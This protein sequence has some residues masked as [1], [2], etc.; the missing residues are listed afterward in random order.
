MVASLLD[1]F[2]EIGNLGASETTGSSRRCRVHPRALEIL[3]DGA[4]IRKKYK[5]RTTR[6]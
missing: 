1:R 4:S 6:F 2:G 3:D 5:L